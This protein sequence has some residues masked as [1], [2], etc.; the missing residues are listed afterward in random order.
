[1]VRE[2]PALFKNLYE[3]LERGV[4]YSEWPKVKLTK[5]NFEGLA[6]EVERI[7]RTGMLASASGD[8]WRGFWENVTSPQSAAGSG[9]AAPPTQPAPQQPASPP[10]P[11]AQQP[12]EAPPAAQQSMRAQPQPQPAKAPPRPAPAPQQASLLE[13][14]QPPQRRA[15]PQPPSAPQQSPLLERAQQPPAELP[16][17]GVPPAVQRPLREAQEGAGPKKKKKR[18]YLDDPED[19]AEL[20]GEFGG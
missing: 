15:P 10:H 4:K 5:S 19:F 1:M 9:G 20:E 13:G 12:T 8:A 14:V 2:E 7:S 18:Y 6:E 17:G 3:N 11:A 16:Q